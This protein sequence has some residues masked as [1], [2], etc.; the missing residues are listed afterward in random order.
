MGKS[1]ASLL[2]RVGKLARL[3]HPPPR[4]VRMMPQDIFLAEDG[5]TDYPG[6]EESNAAARFHAL[7][8]GYE[9][10]AYCGI[11]P[12]WDGSTP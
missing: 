7:V 5:I 3:V 4:R 9:V 6:C 1:V 11:S 10:K 8:W 2:S 12:D